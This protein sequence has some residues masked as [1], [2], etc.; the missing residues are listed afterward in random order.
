MAG[1][2]T[3]ACG[4]APAAILVSRGLTPLACTRTNTWP[5]PGA[6]LGTTRSSSGSLTAVNTI[7]RI[8]VIALPLRPPRNDLKPL[9]FGHLYVIQPSVRHKVRR[10]L[11]ISRRF[12]SSGGRVAGGGSASCGAHEPFDPGWRHPRYR[13]PASVGCRYDDGRAV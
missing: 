12:D 11:R 6:G 10:S 9:G 4:A 1:A 5:D 2:V 7:A 13:N 8:V 3:R